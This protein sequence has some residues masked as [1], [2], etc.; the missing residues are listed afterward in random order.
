MGNPSETLLS[1]GIQQSENFDLQPIL[2]M[3]QSPFVGIQQSENFDFFEGKKWPF[4][5]FVGIQQ[6]ENFD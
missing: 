5:F 4:S 2:V 6:S 3:A 1:V